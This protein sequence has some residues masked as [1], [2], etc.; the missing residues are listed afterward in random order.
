VIEHVLR[1]GETLNA[2]AERYQVSGWQGLY[3][4]DSNRGF[5]QL[6]PDPWCLPVG[7]SIK[8]P[9]SIPEQLSSLAWR[10]HSLES[11]ERGVRRLAAEQARFLSEQVHRSSSRDGALLMSA[12]TRSVVSTTM[13][14]IT[15]LEARDYNARHTD[16]NLLEDALGRWPLIRP[17]ECASLL[18]MLARAS[19]DLPWSI[20]GVAARAWC[21]A[22]SPNYWAKLLQS[23]LRQPDPGSD[24][25]RRSLP[26]MMR[27]HQTASAHVLQNLGAL[28]TGAVM[29]ANHLARL[30][31]SRHTS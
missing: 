6:H 14:A 18:S 29:E 25:I 17:S 5:R 31:L 13:R 11:Q 24:N 12:L 23:L 10:K 19:I 7:V 2:V 27:A 4:A 30:D 21:D 16:L 15:L 28:R 8:I 1:P 22:G 9:D 26:L 3:F 20:S